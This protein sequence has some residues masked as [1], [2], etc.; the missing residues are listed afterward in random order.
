MQWE[1]LQRGAATFSIQLAKGRAEL[2]T[3]MPVKVSGFKQQIDAG[4][5]I[6]T[7]LTHSLSADSGFTTSIELE[8]KID[9]LEMD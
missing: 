8:V 7:T 5:C 4:G 3:E 2:Y 9:A 1:R 6:I